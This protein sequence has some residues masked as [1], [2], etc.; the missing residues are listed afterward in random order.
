MK[1]KII[2]G[3]RGSRLALVQSE[4][5]A[6]ELA[7]LHPDIEVE[8]KKIKTTGDK[9]TDVALA[10][11]GDKGLFVKE[12]ES[13]L[14]DGGIHLAVHS[15]KDMPTKLPEGLEIGAVPERL[16]PLDALISYKYNSLDDLP[17]G[18]VIGTGSLR[19]RAQLAHYRKDLKFV[20][21]RGNLPTRLEKLV[22]LNLDATI[23]AAAGLER[24]EALN[25]HVH[26]LPVAACLPAVGQGALCLEIRSDD[27]YVK[28]L[29][30]P[31]NHRISMTRIKGERAFMRALEGGCQVPIGALAV[32]T[33]GELTLEG[34][35]VSL[36]G[37]RLIRKKIEGKPEEAESMGLALAEEI[38]SGGGRE[39]LQEI[40]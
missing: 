27:E 39:I 2:I 23:L 7:R 37:E 30:E 40:R 36:D 14:L 18:A 20:D 26:T 29:M 8:I 21:I 13:E 31:L 38:L 28:S 5:I 22:S 10:K 12:I 1:R 16:N 11:I 9:I 3:S 35:L 24:L 6:A 34:V 17:Q 33:D 15:M 4:F 25:E 32:I 19:R